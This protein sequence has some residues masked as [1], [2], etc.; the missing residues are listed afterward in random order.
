MRNLIS[1]CGLLLLL[2]ACGIEPVSEGARCLQLGEPEGSAGLVTSLPSKISL[3]FRVDTCG[4]APVSGLDAS[5]FTLQEDGRTV[6]R[7][8]SQQRVQPRGQQF[9]FDSVV[10]LDLS[11]S[12]LRSGDFAALDEAASRYLTAV[13]AAGG[14]SHRVALMTF[15]GRPQPQLVVDFTTDLAALLAGLHSLSTAECSANTECAGFADRRTCAGWRCVDDSTNLNGA[16]VAALDTLE[17]RLALKDV[18][19]RDAA[20]V[21]FTDG[22]DQAGRL[23]AQVAL[24]RAQKTKVHLFSV[25]LGTELDATALAAFGR[26]G[27]FSIRRADQLTAT[28]ETVAARIDALAN[29]FYLLEYCSPRRGGAHTLKLLAQV[30]APGGPLVGGLSGEFDAT[31]FTSGCD[32]T[33]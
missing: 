20:L 31:G 14:D 24:D 12:V 26:D 10:L 33:K 22:T 3:L 8:E 29:R 15:D 13:L 28:F 25:G 27:A 19:W 11:G 21:L 30:D 2:A 16:V 5:A 32:L 9:H 6:S 17:A 18:P 7:Y 23:S 1:S 4:G